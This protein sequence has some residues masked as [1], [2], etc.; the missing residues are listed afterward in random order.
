VVEAEEAE[1][2]LNPTNLSL[3]VTVLVVVEVA[4]V[5]PTVP[6]A[7]DGMSVVVLGVQD[8]LLTVAQE[9]FLELVVV[10]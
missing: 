5:N 4:V 10:V 9:Q 2:V 3:T 7:Q 1:V 6:V 8:S